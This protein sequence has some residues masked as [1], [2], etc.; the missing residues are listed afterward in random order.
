MQALGVKRMG[1]IPEH[2]PT[3]KWSWVTL[4]MGSSHMP[5]EELDEKLRNHLFNHGAFSDRLTAGMNTVIPSS[6][7][8]KDRSKS[9]NEEDISHISYA[10]FCV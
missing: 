8:G 7:K 1:D 3:V 6:K 5:K 2:I 9:M 4:G 10:P